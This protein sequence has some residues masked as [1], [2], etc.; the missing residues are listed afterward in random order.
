[1]RLFKLALP[2]LFATG[3]ALFA[4]R[5]WTDS[6]DRAARAL[7]LEHARHQFTQRAGIARGAPDAEAYR[8]E[9]KAALRAWYAD[10]TDVG[11]RWPMLRGNPPPFVPPPPKAANGGDVREWHDLAEQ[12]VG[13]WREGRVD[14]V[15]SSAVAGLRIDLLRVTK[16]ADHLGVDVA[17]WGAP[18]E[19]EID[20]PAPG[21]QLQR[22]SVPVVFKGLGL[23]FFDAAGKVVAR[24]DAPGEPALRLDMPARL[25]SDAPPGL[26][27]GRYELPLFP[28]DVAEA[29]WTL[30][31][32]VRTASG[33]TRVAQAT[34]KT[35]PEPSWSGA[36]WNDKVVAESESEA[37]AAA[38][39]GAKPAVSTTAAPKARHAA[40]PI[41][42]EQ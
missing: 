40:W 13:G 25:V 24:M 30:A 28:P 39:E 41:R 23:R 36:A 12:H 38:P 29:E 18:E 42:A 27:L 19:T 9:L 10:L 15:E 1:M 22:V 5:A 33:D 32:Q 35:K 26:T 16:L 14:L 2:L 37:K 3:L 21:K 11:N 34:W 8:T 20:E 17:V 6:A 7:A 4:A 31:A